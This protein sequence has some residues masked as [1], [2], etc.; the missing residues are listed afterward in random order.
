MFEPEE[1]REW[2]LM[3]VRLIVDCPNEVMVD[4][5]GKKFNWR[6]RRRHQIAMNLP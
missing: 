2:L 4:A 1:I 5:M 6:D 3:T